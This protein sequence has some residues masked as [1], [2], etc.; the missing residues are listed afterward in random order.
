MTHRL[1]GPLPD[2][3][4][5]RLVPYK[6]S[7]IVPLPFIQSEVMIFPFYTPSGHSVMVFNGEYF[8]EYGTHL[9]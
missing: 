4:L 2:P 8:T 9:T 3:A 7:P 1:L 5:E 6:D